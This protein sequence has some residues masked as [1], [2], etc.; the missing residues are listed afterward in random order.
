MAKVSISEAARLAGKSRSNLYAKYIKN[1][2]LTVEID[3]EN[4][5]VI[6]TADLIRVFGS[7]SSKNSQEDS[8]E[9]SKGQVERT[10]EDSTKDSEMSALQAENKVLREYL[11]AK[12]SEVIWLR[13]QIGKTTALLTHQK[14]N[15]EEPQAKR[16]WWFW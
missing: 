14:P 8:T 16:R 6:D 11:A 10:A 2:A 3:R 15:Q 4:R 5:K 13:E 1:G 9:I 7:L 12:E